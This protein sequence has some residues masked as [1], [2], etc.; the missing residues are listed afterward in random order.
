MIDMVKKGVHS[1]M[2]M[3]PALA[4]ELF[5]VG[6]LAALQHDGPEDGAMMLR[7]KGSVKDWLARNRFVV[8]TPRG[9]TCETSPFVDNIESK[10]L[11]EE[12]HLKEIEELVDMFKADKLQRDIIRLL[13][14]G[15]KKR[16]I[17]NVLGVHEDGVRYQIRKLA[18]RNPRLP[19]LLRGRI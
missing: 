7:I 2:R 10:L 8:S 4:R 6:C 17:A 19:S 14:L 1:Y 3:Y 9:C 15:Y 18:A 11:T 16:E 13:L 5:Q 12:D